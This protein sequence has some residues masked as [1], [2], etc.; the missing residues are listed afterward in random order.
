MDRSLCSSS[1]SDS[2]PLKTTRRSAPRSGRRRPPSGRRQLA[3][4][5]AESNSRWADESPAAMLGREESAAAG[6]LFSRRLA[7][8]Q[9]IVLC[10]TMHKGIMYA[11]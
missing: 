11:V 7:D 2:A 10:N 3:A 8:T 1:D 4:T 5:A 6:P 9:G